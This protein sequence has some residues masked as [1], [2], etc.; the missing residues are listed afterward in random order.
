MIVVETF[1][2][3]PLQCN[4]SIIGCT[5]T[6]EAIIVDPGG[7]PQDI[8]AMCQSKNLKIKY[9][10]HTHAHFD[11]IHGSRAVKEATGAEICLHK[12][13]DWLYQNL[14]MQCQMFNFECDEPLPVDRYLE[15][16][17]E[18]FIGETKFTVMHTPGHT[19]GSVCFSLKYNENVL[20]SGDTLFSR[21]IGRTDLWGGSY[22][23]IIKSIN[24]R[25]MVLEDDTRV[26]TGHGPSTTIWE[27]RKHNPFL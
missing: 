5:E 19:P 24:D 13:D 10:V 15:D 12:E 9:L 26:V 21:S 7:D 14:A 18:L 23:K 17:E 1:P 20:F 8:V 27:E 25:L 3:G 2:V 4:C 11:H 16:E 6:K 22:E